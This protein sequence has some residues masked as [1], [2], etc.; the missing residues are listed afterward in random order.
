MTA[1]LDDGVQLIDV[2]DPST[3]VAAGVATDGVDGFTILDGSTAVT[4]FET[5]GSQYAIVAAA[6]DN[7][8]QLIDLSWAM[9][10]SAP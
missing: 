5:G 2:S 9:P 6:L 4:T 8:V 3:P 1:Y 7:G 10:P